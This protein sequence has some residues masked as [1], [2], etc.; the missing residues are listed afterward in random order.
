MTTLFTYQLG[1]LEQSCF[2]QLPEY[3]FSVCKGGS[4]SG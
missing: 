3:P 2:E 1:L 4:I